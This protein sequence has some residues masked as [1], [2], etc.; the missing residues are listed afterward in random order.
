MKKNFALFL[1]LSAAALML[2]PVRAAC[3]DNLYGTIRGVVKDQSGAVIPGARVT[4]T[5]VETGITR[6]MLSGPDGS[7]E[8]TNL[9]VPAVYDVSVEK[10]GFNK[11][12]NTHIQLNV[13]QIY[14]VPV[15]LQVGSLSQEVTVQAKQAQIETT[16]MQIGGTVGAQQI[17]DLPLNGRNFTQLQQLEPGVMVGS[18]PN[19]LSATC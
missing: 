15:A 7:F 14:V 12:A 17:V 11:Y 19:L 5:N 10:T 16:S 6:H 2:L 8:F 13:N 18:D 4:V 9:T 3:Y 1:I